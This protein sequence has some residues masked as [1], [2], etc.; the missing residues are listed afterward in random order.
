MQKDVH[1]VQ[2]DVAAPQDVSVP[3]DPTSL[4]DEAT[5]H[6]HTIGA[7]SVGY[8]PSTCVADAGG[9]PLRHCQCRAKVGCPVPVVVLKATVNEA[10]QADAGGWGTVAELVGLGAPVAP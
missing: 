8:S 5:V 4:A 1:A 6:G 10:A 3:R 2:H 9:H 7:D